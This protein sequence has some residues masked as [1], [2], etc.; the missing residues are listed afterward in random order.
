LPETGPMDLSKSRRL[1]YVLLLALLTLAVD[2]ASKIWATQHLANQS[3]HTYL[4]VLTLTYSQNFGGWG[5]LGAHWGDWARMCVFLVLPTFFLIG[6]IVHTVSHAVNRWELAGA[7]LLLAG[8]GSNLIDRARLGYVQDFLYLGYGPIGTNIFN[9]AD[10]AI[11]AGIGL[12]LAGPYLAKDRRAK[13]SPPP[14][15]SP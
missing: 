11:L 4:A 2:Q 5:S 7:A 1:A 13:S 9:I 12:L 6:L 3:P 15:S 8:G 14:A 10:M